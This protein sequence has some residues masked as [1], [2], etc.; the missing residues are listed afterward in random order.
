[1]KVLFKTHLRFTPYWDC[2]PNIEY[3]GRKFIN[4]ATKDKISLN[5]GCVDGSV[6]ND[7]REPIL[8][9]LTLDKPPVS[10]V[11]CEPEAGKV[12]TTVLNTVKSY[13]DYDGSKELNFNGETLTFTSQ[14]KN[15]CLPRRSWMQRPSWD[16]GASH[17]FQTV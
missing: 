13:L 10:K 3:L 7:I 8:F 4:I 16:L 2:K 14:L 5:C 6:V 1:M 17:H 9:S 15:S 12:N 11:F